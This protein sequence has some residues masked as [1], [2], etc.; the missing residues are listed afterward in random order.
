MIAA[1]RIDGADSSAKLA[2]LQITQIFRFDNINEKDFQTIEQLIPRAADILR[3]FR[4]IVYEYIKRNLNQKYTIKTEDI[5]RFKVDIDKIQQRIL[6]VK[7]KE[8][9]DSSVQSELI[10]KA[11]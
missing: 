9:F 2:S 4:V 8:E 7:P 6:K 3:K 11:A 5:G 10:Q 1:V